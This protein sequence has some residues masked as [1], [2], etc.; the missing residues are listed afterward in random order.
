MPAFEDPPPNVGDPGPVVR[1]A[2][3]LAWGVGLYLRRV[4]QLRGVGQDDYAELVRAFELG[5][6]GPHPQP[7]EQ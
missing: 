7:E 3:R 5:L 6:F 1:W 4:L 2:I